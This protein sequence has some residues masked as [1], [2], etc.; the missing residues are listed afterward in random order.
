[1]KS[2][3]SSLNAPAWINHQTLIQFFQFLS[4]YEF[5]HGI[6]FSST[7]CGTFSFSRFHMCQYAFGATGLVAVHDRKGRSTTRHGNPHNVSWVHS[8][9][10]FGHKAESPGAVHV[11]LTIS[12]SAKNASQIQEVLAH[13]FRNKS[14]P[15]TY[16]KARR[17]LE[18]G[19]TMPIAPNCHLWRTG[20]H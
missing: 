3:T 15:S 19:F 14:I 13:I 11:F 16:V 17:F 1:M 20:R 4:C 8:F 6:L 5:S 12:S 9:E 2:S 10:T 7:P 18:A